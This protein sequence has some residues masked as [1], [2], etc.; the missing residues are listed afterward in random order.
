MNDAPVILSAADMVRLLPL[1]IPAGAGLIA[2][3]IAGF[4]PDD[5]SLSPVVVALA[6]LAAIAVMLFRIWPDARAGAPLVG[7]MLVMDSYALFFAFLVFAMLAGASSL[8]VAGY[9]ARDFAHGEFWA[10]LLF[11]A[12][13]MVLL[14]SA[15]NLVLLFIGVEVMS[16]SVYAMVGSDRRRSRPTEAAMKYFLLGAFSSAFLLFGI[17]LLY[18]A[19]GSLDLAAIGRAVAAGHGGASRAELMLG[20]ALL[21]VGFGFK[22]ATVP[23]HMW[24]PD[25]YTGAPSSVTAFMASAVKAASFAAFVRVFATSLAP[26]AWFW[27]DVVAVMAAVTIVVGNLGAIAQSDLKR[28]LAYSSIAHAGYLLIGLRGASLDP[29]LA[30]PAILYYLLAYT[31]TSLGTFGAVV[32]IER[33]QGRE[34]AIKDLAGTAARH[35]AIAAALTVFMLAL[36]GVPPTAGFTAKL[37]VF[38]SVVRHGDYLLAVIGVLGSVVS[39]Y[40]YL[41]VVVY[42]YMQEPDP[43]AVASPEA[44]P[45]ASMPSVGGTVAVAAVIVLLAGIAPDWYVRLSDAAARSALGTSAPRAEAQIL[46]TAT[47]ARQH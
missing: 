28:M 9:R 11:A 12:T 40:Y 32:A 34:L 13:G 17:A 47:A 6:S 16:I 39:L 10:L 23:F 22:T 30:T 21:L 35:P 43:D 3:L 27:S 44:E 36:A 25:A 45:R 18:G 2:L 5:R 20:T 33:W 4:K 1:L 26:S 8:A 38:G 24:A 42:L 7:G 14:V 19:T 46:P 31:F 15:R 37:F 29:A 41:R